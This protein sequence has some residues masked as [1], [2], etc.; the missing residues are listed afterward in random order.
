MEQPRNRRNFNSTIVCSAFPQ[1]LT[2][3]AQKFY[4]A[5]RAI[6]SSVYPAIVRLSRGTTPSSVCPSFF[7]LEA[8]TRSECNLV[9]GYFAWNLADFSFLFFFSENVSRCFTYK[10]RKEEK[11]K[12]I[13]GQNSLLSSRRFVDFFDRG[14][15]ASLLSLLHSFIAIL[16][17]AVSFIS[18]V[19]GGNQQFVV[20]IYWCLF[21]RG[22]KGGF[23]GIECKG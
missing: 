6:I 8:Y 19:D 12:K 14:I 1:K 4:R 20:N 16:I 22:T 21:E 9:R 13:G 5:I 7:S 10:E 23:I 11:R 2:E 15:E 17:R 3:V 18:E